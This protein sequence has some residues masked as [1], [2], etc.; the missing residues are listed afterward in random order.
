MARGN[1]FKKNEDGTPIPLG[2][3]S[4]LVYDKAVKD[5][6]SRHTQLII[7]DWNVTKRPLFK[8]QRVSQYDR[9]NYILIDDYSFQGLLDI[10]KYFW[11][12][13]SVLGTRARLYFLMTH[14]MLLRSENALATKLTKLFSMDLHD[15][16]LGKD[17]S[18]IEVNLSKLVKHSSS[19]EVDLKKY[20]NVS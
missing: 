12:R 17:V 8:N 9:R 5:L 13:N 4:I 3:E 6:Y 18:I 20:F 15:Q 16:G 10:S 11:S 7:R 1:K 2:D 14:V 19:K